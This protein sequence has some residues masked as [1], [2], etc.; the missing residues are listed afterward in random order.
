MTRVSFNISINNDDTFEDNETFTLIINTSSLP[1]HVI[2]GS[3]GQATVT[4]VD[5]DCKLFLSYLHQRKSCE[6]V[7]MLNKKM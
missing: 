5:D 7:L 4:I 1:S 2:V 3:P 6:N